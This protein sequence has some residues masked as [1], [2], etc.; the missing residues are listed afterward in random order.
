MIYYCTIHRDE[1]QQA[2]LGEKLDAGTSH[3]VEATGYDLEGMRNWVHVRQNYVIW[4]MERDAN[5]KYGWRFARLAGIP[6]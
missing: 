4:E 2:L 5:A 1:D 6:R 3:M